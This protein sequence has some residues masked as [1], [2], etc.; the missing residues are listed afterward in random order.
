VTFYTLNRPFVLCEH[1]RLGNRAEAVAKKI[2]VSANA[3]DEAEKR[4]TSADNFPLKIL[5]GTGVRIHSATRIPRSSLRKG[6]ASF[7]CTDPKLTR[8]GRDY[9]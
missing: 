1:C 7:H 4:A 9:L 3:I 6:G 8:I 2:S 5:N